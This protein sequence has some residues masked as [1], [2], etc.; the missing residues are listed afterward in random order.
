M[1]LKLQLFLC[2]LKK[3]I[4]FF[5]LNFVFFSNALSAKDQLIVAVGLAKPPYVIQADDSG[6]ELDLIRNILKKMGKSTKFVYTQFG[7]SSKMLEVEEVD[8]VMT[9]N[10][11]VF[12]DISK[13]SDAYITYQNVA[14][15]LKQSNITINT[16]EDLANFSIASFQ[17]ADKVL[18]Q[19]FADAVDKS[20]LYMKIADQSQ[21][22]GLLLKKRAEVLIMDINIF[23]YFAGEL[24]V[25]D[26]NGQFVFHQ[27]F[28][29]THYKMAFKNK[30]YV[31]IFND[32]FA[33]YKQTD[34]YL[35]LRNK[36]N[37]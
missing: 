24:N 1:A 37:L 9:T 21:Q 36:Y 7:H 23:K 5:T 32:T 22:P 35:F 33:E 6:F 15:S 29:E 30:K 20:P 8:A 2:K 12:S 16:I 18:G 25:N 28:P 26:I 10:Q 13:L 19:V 27:I 34:D 14:I 17:K 3:T 31:R 4:F 11:N